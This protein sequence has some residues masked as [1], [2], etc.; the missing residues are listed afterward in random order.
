MKPYTHEE[1]IALGCKLRDPGNLY[2][3][4]PEGYYSCIDRCVIEKLVVPTGEGS[5]PC[6]II[7][8]LG[9][10]TNDILYIN[11]HGGGFVQIHHKWDTEMCAYYAVEMGF[12]V[13]DVDYRLSPEYA[14]PA[15]IHDCY[16]VTNY[17][18]DHAAELGINPEKIVIGGNSAG[19]TLSLDVCMMAKEK[20]TFVPDF[21]VMV[22]PAA[23]NGHGF[24]DIPYED[25]LKMD[26]KDLNMRAALY[27]RLYLDDNTEF[28]AS[29]YCD[30]LNA[31]EEMFSAVPDTVIVTGELDPLRIGGEKLPSKLAVA[32]R[33]VFLR[34]FPESNHGFYVRCLGNHWKEARD[35]VLNLIASRYGIPH[36]DSQKAD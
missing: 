15:A 24:Q 10:C 29:P 5:V 32:C 4:L 21:M 14:Y 23:D 31:P 34:R 30:F 12:T 13:V 18:H 27:N 17:C 28:Q 36:R 6:D 26:L 35:F 16:S 11:I 1:K 9:G 8:P 33:S 2:Y 19:A 20:N 7:R 22:Y 25:A 3:K